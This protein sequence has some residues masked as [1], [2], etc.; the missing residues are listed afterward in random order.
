[1]GKIHIAFNRTDIQGNEVI[2]ISNMLVPYRLGIFFTMVSFNNKLTLN[3]VYKERNLT[4]PKKFVKC[5][6]K[7][8][9]QFM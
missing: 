6:D 5:L 8:Y 1:M 2:N 9:K 7:I 3:V 4:N